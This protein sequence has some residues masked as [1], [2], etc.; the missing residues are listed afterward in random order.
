LKPNKTKIQTKRKKAETKVRKQVEVKV[1]KDDDEEEREVQDTTKKQK[2]EARRVLIWVMPCTCRRFVD[3]GLRSGAVQG[4]AD[5]EKTV[6][7]E[8]ACR[9]IGCQCRRRRVQIAH[10]KLVPIVKLDRVT[11]M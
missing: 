8:H 11:H 2:R 4:P 6:S 9:M 1:K 10:I 7:K 5:W 3:T